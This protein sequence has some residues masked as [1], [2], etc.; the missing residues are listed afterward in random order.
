MNKANKTNTLNP[1]QENA[2][3]QTE[4]PVIIIAGPGSGKTRVITER[5]A[6]LLNTGVE[7]YNILALTF[8]NK[9]ANE[10]KKR[11][12]E[13]TNTQASYSVWMGTFHSIFAKILRKEA[14]CLGYDYNFTIYDN[15]DSVKI[16]RRIIKD[17]NLDKDKYDGFRYFRSQL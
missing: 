16:I 3:K 13:I 5:I 10:M 12:Y 7:P 15:E 9:A 2:I 8:T 1:Q 11:V 14:H 17:H 6:H 4:G